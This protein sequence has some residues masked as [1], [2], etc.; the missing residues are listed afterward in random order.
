VTRPTA[1]VKQTHAQDAARIVRRITEAI[2]TW[3]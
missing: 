3:P 1:A 2:Q